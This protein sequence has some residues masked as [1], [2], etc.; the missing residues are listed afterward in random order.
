MLMK[1]RISILVLCTANIFSFLDNNMNFLASRSSKWGPTQGP[2]PV[3][4]L[5]IAHRIDANDI[6]ILFLFESKFKKK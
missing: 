3:W 4:E 5:K 2:Y 6:F 1:F